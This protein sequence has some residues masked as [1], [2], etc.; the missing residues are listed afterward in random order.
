[1]PVCFLLKQIPLITTFLIWSVSY[2]VLPFLGCIEH[3]GRYLFGVCVVTMFIC[4]SGVFVLSMCAISEIFGPRHFALAFGL[5][6]TAV[7]FDMFVEL[8]GRNFGCS[9]E[10]YSFIWK[11]G[12]KLL[13]RLREHK[14]A[15]RRL[16]PNSR[17]TT[18]IGETGHT[19]DM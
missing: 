15:M 10:N 6:S 13:T 17:V 19:L 14:L 18:N 9:D 16:D 4:F 11:N 7:P 2:V 1:M 12:E 3:A 5:V 8:P